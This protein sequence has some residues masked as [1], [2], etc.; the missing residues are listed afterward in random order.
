METIWDLL[1]C[2]ANIAAQHGLAKPYLVGGAVR[3]I[4][5]DKKPKDYDITT[6]DSDVFE[7]AHA[8][9]DHFSV[10]VRTLKSG[11]RKLSV[12]GHEL[13]FSNNFC[14][15]EFGTGLK[16]ETQSRDFTINSILFDLTDGTL[17]DYHGGVED[18]KAKRLRCP[19]DPE[20]SI[21]SDPARAIR[22]IKY[23]AEGFEPEQAVW[24]AVSRTAPQIA[25]LPHRY[26]G[27]VLN[28]AIR[29]NP[30]IVTA[31]IERGL[32]GHMPKTHELI[33]QLIRSRR[34]VDAL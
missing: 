6:G 14:H 12:G 34:L 15:P 3:D 31:L 21:G 18:L 32:I 24:D 19:C 33:N 13:D 8:V 1:S 7:L 16:A 2:I 5:S 23:F 27:K 17:H 22:A 25:D 10:P 4:L 29:T 11:S 9:G 20:L 26:S 28:Q 30:E